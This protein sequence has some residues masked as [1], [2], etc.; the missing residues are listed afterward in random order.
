MKARLMFA[1]ALALLLLMPSVCA[2][3]LSSSDE[4]QEETST[5]SEHIPNSIMSGI[6]AVSD[7]VSVRADSAVLPAGAA[8]H[9]DRFPVR[10]DQRLQERFRTGK[11]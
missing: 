4:P 11:H 5:F 8:E 10:D 6:D 7:A 1:F 3:D 9:A 2:A